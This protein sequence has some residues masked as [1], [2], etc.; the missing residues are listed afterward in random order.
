MMPMRTPSTVTIRDF[1][2]HAGVVPVAL[3]IRFAERNGNVA[4]FAFFLRVPSG[5]S[6]GCFAMTAG[7]IGP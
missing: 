1:F 7:P 5:S 4:S 2:A 6:D 3:S